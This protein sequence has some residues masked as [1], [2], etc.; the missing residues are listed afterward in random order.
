MS[1]D[2]IYAVPG[3]TIETWESDL[4]A[5]VALAPEH[6]SAYALTWEDATPYHAWRARGRLR[7]LADDT[8]AAMAETTVA[9]LEAAGFRRYE[10]SSFARPGRE[11]RHNVGYWDGS[12]YLGVGPGAHSFSATPAPGRRWSNERLPARWLADVAA[13]GVAIATEERLTGAQARAEFVFTG[14]RRLAGVDAV[15]F[16]R[17]FGTSLHAAFPQLVRLAD[18][19]LVED[20]AGRVRLTARGLAFADSVGAELV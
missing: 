8:E 20:A 14:L 5:A 15:A 18:D 13:R 4:A 17:R 16:E 3:T 9:H 11:S 6:V 12:D 2:L 1:L 10:I 19:G 7:P